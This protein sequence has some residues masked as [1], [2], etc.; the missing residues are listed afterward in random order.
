MKILR[1]KHNYKSNFLL[2]GGVQAGDENCLHLFYYYPRISGFQK[3][4][5][6]P[7]FQD[8]LNT[9]SEMKKYFFKYYLFK[10]LLGNKSFEI[11]FFIRN[12]YLSYSDL[13]DSSS[14]NSMLSGLY[15]A[16]DNLRSVK[17]FTDI[18]K[19][20]LFLLYSESDFYPTCHV[21][22]Q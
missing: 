7:T 18:M 19:R 11:P 4:G 22:I 16:F 13:Y 5:S 3:C 15:D 6:F 21:N 14:A 17:N 8:Q 10:N 9:F 2:K 12:G 20:K 1:I